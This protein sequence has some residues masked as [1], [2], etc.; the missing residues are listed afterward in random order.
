MDGILEPEDVAECVIQGLAEETFLILPHPTVKTY[1]QRK[2]SDYDRWNKR[3][4]SLCTKNHS[5]HERSPSKSNLKDTLKHEG[6]PL[7]RKIHLIS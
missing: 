2:A 6:D 5:L 1:Y 3:H 7:C 4:V